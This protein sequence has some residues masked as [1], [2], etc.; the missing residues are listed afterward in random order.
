MPSFE[1]HES[2]EVVKLLNLGNSGSGKTGAVACLVDAGLKI[3]A[4]DFDNGLGVLGGYVKDKKKLVENVHYITLRDK[5]KLTGSRIGIQK[6][7]AFQRAMDALDGGPKAAKLWGT[8]DKPLD[9]G[10]VTSWGSDVVLLLDT[11]ALAGKASLQMVM[12][13]NGKGFSQPEIQHYGTAMD[14]IEKLLDILTSDAVKCHVIVNTHTATPEGQT[15]PLPEALGSKLSPK[16]GKFFDN[17]FSTSLTAGKRTIKTKK[18]GLIACKSAIP[19]DEAY[20]IEDGLLSIFKKL[21]GKA[22]LI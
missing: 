20:P 21:T 14:N 22:S 10:P 18:D 8:D 5:M 11:L 17:M 9:F 12:A 19:L 15:I 4:L 13:A 16:V 2:R 1:Q 7:D 3:R 6:G